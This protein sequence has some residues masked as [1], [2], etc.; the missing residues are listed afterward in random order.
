[1]SQM[2][3]QFKLGLF[4]LGGV[5]LVLAGLFTFGLRRRLEEKTDFETYVP[6]SVGGIAV[7]SAVKL[8]G[9]SVGEVTGLDFSWN[10]Y[11]GGNPP[12]VVV[13]FN[14]KVRALPRDFDLDQ[15][16]RRGLRAIVQIE[17]ITGA[18][19]LALADVDP[20]ENPPLQ[21]SWTP[22]HPVIPSAPSQLDQML[23]SVRATLASL[24][25][26]DF[27]RLA[28]RL[29]HLMVTGDGTLQ[30]ISGD[31]NAAVGRFGAASAE[32]GAL[33]KEAR[34][35]LRGMQLEALGRDANGLVASIQDTNARL[36]G[37]IDRL[38][39]VEVRD[40]HETLASIR[41]AVGGL[42]DVIADL[43][44][45]PSGFLFGEAPPPAQSVERSR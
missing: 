45:Y 44:R 17:G 42:N 32:A 5:A 29:D 1:M 21:F 10:E 6:E 34:T 2:Q 41:E 39:D 8:L 12:S 7:G 11:P 37:L 20:A 28:E 15:A 31:L 16:I 38:S 9:V 22:R 33:A 43:R 30:R 19:V 26:V 36:Q 13:H 27:A 18:A 23:R 25:R 24:Q 35:E 40:L 3:R 14:V 4:V